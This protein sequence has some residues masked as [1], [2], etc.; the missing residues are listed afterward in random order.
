MAN[1]LV[2]L[3][4][5]C[6]NWSLSLHAFMEEKVVFIQYRRAGPLGSQLS[7]ERI[8]MDIV[9]VNVMGGGHFTDT[10]SEY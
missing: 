4:F 6:T 5:A 1:G 10:R 7:T 2:S 8:A 9:F 3:A